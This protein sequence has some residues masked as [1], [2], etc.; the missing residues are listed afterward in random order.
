MATAVLNDRVR[1]CTDACADCVE[2]CEACARHCI[3]SGTTEMAECVK[4]CLELRHAV[5]RLSP[6]HGPRLPLARRAV[7]GV[8]RCV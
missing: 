2:A 5:R 3:D 6:A 1:A 7:P 8:R 4:L